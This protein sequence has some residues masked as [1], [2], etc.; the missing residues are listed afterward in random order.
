MPGGDGAWAVARV[1]R[2]VGR[3]IG[4][5]WARRGVILVEGGAWGLYSARA[6]RP[7]ST[8]KPPRPAA[9]RRG[10]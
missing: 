10:W 9:K 5:D 2:G 4:Q 3:S 7:W 8:A 1:S 6:R